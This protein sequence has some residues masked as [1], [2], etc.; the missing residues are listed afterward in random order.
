MAK[1]SK[2]TRERMAKALVRHRFNDRAA[3]LTAESIAIYDALYD[4]RYDAETQKLIAKLVKRDK[5]AFQ[6]AN[7][8]WVNAG[9]YRLNIGAI[10]VGDY[11]IVRWHAT[12]EPKPIFYSEDDEVPAAMV[13]RVRDF[14]SASKTFKEEVGAAY[15][16]AM[17]T[18]NSLGTAKRLQD[19]W[20]EA[21]P[22]I[23]DLIPTEDRSVPVVQL[24]GIND[25]FGLP[26]EAL[27]A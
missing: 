11:D 13:E 14:A 9:G 21:M 19:E 6:T 23:G 27:A 18:L 24:S 25:E 12:S 20:P 5:R 10:Y 4:H 22:V 1:L 7:T 3:E 26:P 8:D 17:A 16:K 15:A 2:S